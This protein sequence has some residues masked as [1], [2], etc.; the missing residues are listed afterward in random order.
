MTKL[1]SLPAIVLCGLAGVASAADL[2]VLD[3]EGYASSDFQ[4]E[5]AA[6]HGRAASY[7]YFDFEDE[8]FDSVVDGVHVDVAHICGGSLAKWRDAGL[9]EPWDTARAKTTGFGNLGFPLLPEEEALAAYTMPYIYGLDLPVYNSAEV[10]AKDMES[11]DVFVD[12]V[13]AG[14]TALPAFPDGLFALGFLATGVTDWSNPSDEEFEA[15]V[16]WLERAVQNAHSFWTVAED[17]AELM[18]THEV[19]IAWGWN[20]IGYMARS[21]DHNIKIARTPKEGIGVWVCGTVKL[22]TDPATEALAYDFANA[23]ASSNGLPATI[24]YAEGYPDLEIMARSVSPEDMVV[25]GLEIP[26]GPILFET[27]V[28]PDLRERMLEAIARMR[29]N[30]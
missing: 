11:L 2:T 17:V 21:Y 7:I 1:F 22:T 24:E 29:E 9:I 28:R 27:P 3:Y 19:L 12:P 16:A 30:M 14:R 13:Y 5:F 4:P 10:P 18:G 6:K 26:E 25:Y 20:S 23:R 15:A 8:A